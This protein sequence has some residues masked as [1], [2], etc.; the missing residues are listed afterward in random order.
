MTSA[1]Q[2]AQRLEHFEIFG[3]ALR[4]YNKIAD[5]LANEAMDRGR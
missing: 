1:Q 4:E 2:L 5:R 3:S